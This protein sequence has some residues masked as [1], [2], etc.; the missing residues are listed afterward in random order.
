[1]R[2]REKEYRNDLCKRN[3]CT[4]SDYYYIC[5]IIPPFIDKKWVFYNQCSYLGLN[6]YIISLLRCQKLLQVLYLV[7]TDWNKRGLFPTIKLSAQ[8][9]SRP[10]GLEIQR[11]LKIHSR[12][13]EFLYRN[14]NRIKFK[15]KKDPQ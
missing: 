15:K 14:K 4:G 2:G 6:K 11:C 9:G 5:L 10:L 13:H 7:Y 3:R 12:E 8:I 1:M